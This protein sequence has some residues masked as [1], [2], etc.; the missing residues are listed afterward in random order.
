MSSLFSEL[1]LR[2]LTLQNRLVAAPMCQYSAVDG[3]A[4]DYHLVQHGRFSL[5]GFGTM[6]IEAT[7]VTPE[8]RISHGDLGLWDDQ[9]I[10]PLQRIASFLKEQGTVPAIQLSH[11]GRKAATRRPWRGD[12]PVVEID[13]NE[14]GD[15]PWTTIA[16]SAEPHAKGYPIPVALDEPGIE[17]LVFA[18]GDAARRALRAGFKIVEVHCAHGYLLN[19]FLS[20]IANKRDDRYGGSLD[21]RMRLPIAVVD[22]V[23]RVW[24]QD[25]P[26]FV[27][28][29]AADH[30]DG[31]WTSNDSIRLAEELK[32]R[33]VD[34]IDCSSGGF[35]GAR[36]NAFT[37]SHIPYAARIAKQVLIPTMTVGLI[38]SPQQAATAVEK[39]GIAL[40]GLAREALLNPNLPL[41][42]SGVLEGQE[43]SPKRWPKQA[44][45]ALGGYLNVARSN[46]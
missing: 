26:V 4:S 13:L 44:V 12:G 27:R 31:G 14:L 17:H 25:L 42:Y 18:F 29:S 34:L 35:D 21:N 5:G 10:A 38:R 33:G 7:A 3:V 41:R 46:R 37:T 20:P 8:G 39:H 22:E 32:R 40:V 28:V 6:M 9:Q 30:I 24:P 19:Q 2:G 1:R 43:V 11:A 16:P 45:W 15:A 23:R 36:Q